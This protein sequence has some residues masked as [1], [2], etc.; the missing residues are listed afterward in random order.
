MSGEL[1]FELPPRITLSSSRAEIEQRFT[2][3]P[4]DHLEDL[5][6][7]VYEHVVDAINF[8]AL[9]GLEPMLWTKLDALARRGRLG[10]FPSDHVH[11]LASELVARAIDKVVADT[12]RADPLLP[13]GDC[14]CCRLEMEMANR[15]D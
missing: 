4:F 13:F 2:L 15:A 10:A 11:E 3:V 1:Q 9:L 5:E 8:D 6:D 14:E 12:W 7:I